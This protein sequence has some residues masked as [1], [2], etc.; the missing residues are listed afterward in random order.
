[1]IKNKKTIVLAMLLAA[2]ALTLTACGSKD[3]EEPTSVENSE[4]AVM[5]SGDVA[6]GSQDMESTNENTDLGSTIGSMED[7]SNT[8]TLPVNGEPAPE[9]TSAPSN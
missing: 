9:P 6:N 1:M 2:S 8:Q 5:P 3:K 4:T 7:S